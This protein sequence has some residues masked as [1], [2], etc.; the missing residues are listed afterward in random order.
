[1][2]YSDIECFL[3]RIPT[4]Q[5]KKSNYTKRLMARVKSTLVCMKKNEIHKRMAFPLVVSLTVI[6]ISRRSS[7]KKKQTH[8]INN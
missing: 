6:T 8:H 5:L 1:M 2:L 4:S 7:E 3:K